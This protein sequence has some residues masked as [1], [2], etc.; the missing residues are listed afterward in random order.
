M[1]VRPDATAPV[2]R[3]AAR[4]REGLRLLD[5]GAVP[6]D[7]AA[8][9]GASIAEQR[10]IERLV[11]GHL[12]RVRVR[13]RGRVGLGFELGVELGCGFGSGFGFGVGAG[14]RVLGYR[15]GRVVVG[16]EVT[17]LQPALARP[18]AGAEAACPPG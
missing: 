5:L 3:R 13:V 7:V 18:R 10:P 4:R 16:V 15:D 17:E 9:Q 2:P 1:R 6:V 11:L 8:Q 14:G 12:V